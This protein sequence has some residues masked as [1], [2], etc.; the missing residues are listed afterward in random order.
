MRSDCRNER[1]YLRLSPWPG[2]RRPT[3][4]E[5]HTARMAFSAHVDMGSPVQ[6]CRAMANSSIKAAATICIQG[7]SLKAVMMNRN[8]LAR[9]KRYGHRDLGFRLAILSK[10][11]SPT[12]EKKGRH[13][14]PPPEK[15]V[16]T[17]I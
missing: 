4:T 16:R 11:K 12:R 9:S 10:Q 15:T 7:F 17:S 2:K 3:Y 13:N 1:Q 5:L 6:R 14:S 8:P